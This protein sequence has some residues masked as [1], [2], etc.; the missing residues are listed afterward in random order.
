[1]KCPHCQKDTNKVKRE[2]PKLGDIVYPQPY[3]Y[4]WPA[5]EAEIVYIAREVDKTKVVGKHRIMLGS[6]KYGDYS[7]GT[8]EHCRV[9][10]VDL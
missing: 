4:G 5:A 2:M 1:M 6:L 3:Q 7:I 8:L 9:K 10:P